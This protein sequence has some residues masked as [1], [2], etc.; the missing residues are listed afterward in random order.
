[1]IDQLHDSIEIS[2]LCNNI[3]DSATF[4]ICMNKAQKIHDKSKY[5]KHLK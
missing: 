2:N 1:M 3:Y 4:T 5:N